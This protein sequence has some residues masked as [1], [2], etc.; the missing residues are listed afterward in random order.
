MTSFRVSAE[1]RTLIAE[2]DSMMTS[3][4]GLDCWTSWARVVNLFGAKYVISSAASIRI[5]SV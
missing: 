1:S 2:D 5:T 4:A 3:F